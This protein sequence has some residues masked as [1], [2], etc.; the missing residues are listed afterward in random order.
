MHLRTA[1]I[2]GAAGLFNGLLAGC[3]LDTPAPRIDNATPGLV[4]LSDDLEETFVI[5]GQNLG[6]AVVGAL[7]DAPRLSG[8]EVTLT[9]ARGLDGGDGSGLSITLSEGDP[10]LSVAS[11]ERLDVSLDRFLGLEA[12]RFDLRVTA[13]GADP[14]VL[15]DA[16]AVVGAPTELAVSPADVCQSEGET[17]LVIE[18]SGL[19]QVNGE[20]VTITLGDDTVTPDA[21]EGCVPLPQDPSV[22][23]CERAT[24]TVSPSALSTGVYGL[25]LANPA[26]ADCEESAPIALAVRSPPT[27]S[28][29]TPDEVC[30]TGTV[31]QVEGVRLV[32]DM[33][34]TV[35]GVALGPVDF[36]DS[37]AVQVVVPDGALPPGIHDLSLTSE[38]GCDAALAEAVTVRVPP[39]TFAVDPPFAPE[40]RSMQVLASLAGVFDEITDVTLL[41]EAGAAVTPTWTWDPEQPDRV[42]VTLPDTL[43]TG[44]WQVVVD[45]GADCPG[46][47]SATVEVLAA[48]DLPLASVEPAQAWRF[49]PTAIEVSLTDPLPTGATGLEPGARAWLVDPTGA[50]PPARVYATEAR[51]ETLL[52]G[53]VPEGLDTGDLDL[54]V[55]NPDG[56]AG[57]LEA[58]LEIVT[59][60][61]PVIRSVTPGTLENRGAPELTLQGAGFRDPTVELVCRDGAIETTLST[62][63]VSSTYS[64]AVVIPDVASLNQ[65]VCVVRLEN[66]D[67]AS[68]RFSAVSVTN[69]AQNLFPWQV[70]PTLNTARRAPAAAAGRTSSVRRW[71]YAI[72][73]DA[74]D[75]SSA[76]TS[77]EVAPVGVYGDLGAWRPQPR[78]LPVPR[79][80]AGI[81]RIADFLYLVGGSDHSAPVPSTLRAHILDPLSAPFFESIALT[82]ADAGLAPG[83]WSYRV[84]AT[85]AADDATNPGGEGLAADLVV[86]T[87]PDTGDDWAVTL[88]WAPVPDAVGYRIYRAPDAGAVPGL[89]EVLLAESTTASFTDT[90][91]AVDPAIGPLREGDLGEWATVERLVIPRASMCVTVA[92]DPF[93]DPHVVYLYAAGGTDTTGQPRHLIEVLPVT[94]EGPGRQ[95]LG[96]WQILPTRLSQARTRCGAMTLDATWHSVVEPGESWVF[97]AGGVANSGPVGTVDAFYVDERGAL[98]SDGTTRS[99]T[100]AR[101]GFAAASASNFLYAFGGQQDTPSAGGASAELEPSRIPNVRNWNS[102]STGLS[103]PRHLP[104]STQ[105]SAVLFVVGGETDTDAAS[106]NVDW[107]NF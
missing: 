18:G 53:I 75:P 93:P 14:R 84:S 52:A 79:T 78:S 68:A 69:P 12:G 21:L 20:P 7:G 89:D 26:P 35:G 6:P 70:G 96:S 92:D 76:L 43:H 103:A 5:R 24:L 15:A 57:L 17:T 90:G 45:Q 28:V 74:G 105:E 47:P 34:A 72:G 9:A 41:D 106:D 77:I 87:V 61:P 29:V 86:I 22:E 107:T 101:A 63:P 25:V 94:I 67:G 49:S 11:A 97:F 2:A 104:G 100:P 42:Q 55:L 50:R 85:F 33:Q 82:P 4:C 66:A 16:L 27:V 62:T 48:S 60:E 91:G 13:G 44:P 37:R 71:L 30:D 10:R 56:T 46:T 98:V 88:S 39:V 81:V 54:L 102:L 59:L 40:G 80:L 3:A 1:L 83:T 23:V 65:A 99:M 73:G 19:L 31:L 95:T 58:A 51:S 8:P 38:G 64:A 36:I 32:A